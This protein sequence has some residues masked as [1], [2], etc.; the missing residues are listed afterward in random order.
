[1][2]TICTLN[3]QYRE[4]KY[5]CGICGWSQKEAKRRE[6]LLSTNGLTVC[7]DGMKRLIIKR[8]VSEE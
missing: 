6:K 3:P 8:K 1:M 5:N 7:K 4:C 2:L